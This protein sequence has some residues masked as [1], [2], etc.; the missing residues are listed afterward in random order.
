MAPA[1]ACQLGWERAPQRKHGTVGSSLRRTV[2]TPPL[3]PFSSQSLASVLE[4]RARGP[5]KRMPGTPACHLTGTESPLVPTARC[6]D[7]S[8]QLWS[9][10]LGGWDPSLLGG[11]SVLLLG[12]P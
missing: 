10:G 12:Y 7:S 11:P 5:F 2:L 6:E 4:L 8:S 1:C 3:H 9:P